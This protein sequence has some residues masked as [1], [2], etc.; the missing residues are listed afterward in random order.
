MQLELLLHE[1]ES[2]QPDCAGLPP[3]S[4]DLVSATIVDR[5]SFHSSALRKLRSPEITLYF[6][7]E[8][9]R[10][11]RQL[12]VFSAGHGRLSVATLADYDPVRNRWTTDLGTRYFDLE[13][14]RQ[15]KRLALEMLKRVDT[16]GLTRYQGST[17]VLESYYGRR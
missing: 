8:T 9:T 2:N 3:P 4:G 14:P 12:K 16:S 11:V 10:E 1:A 6:D 7:S 17:S 5:P 15:A 13:D